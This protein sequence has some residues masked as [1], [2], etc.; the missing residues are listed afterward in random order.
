ASSY[1]KYLIGQFQGS[2]EIVK[3][4]RDVEAGAGFC[5]QTLRHLGVQ[6]H[7]I[8]WIY[9]KKSFPSMCQSPPY[10]APLLLLWNCQLE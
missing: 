4:Q 9:L 8:F 6:R 1:L 7:E 2:Y 3:L 10:I 5:S